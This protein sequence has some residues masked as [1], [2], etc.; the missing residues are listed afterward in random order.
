MSTSE[1]E[2]G[3]KEGR[4]EAEIAEHGRRLNAVNGNI[5]KFAA[6][7]EHLTGEVRQIREQMNLEVA[8]QKVAAE[9]LA[10]ETERR[11]R[12]LATEAMAGDRKF[13][14]R[15]R[16]FAGVISLAATLATIYISL[17]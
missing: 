11:R 12:E 17:H 15:E 1:F 4:D 6:A 14:R 2:R 9:V 5:A 16:L 13:T 8:R 7:V 10:A 3:R